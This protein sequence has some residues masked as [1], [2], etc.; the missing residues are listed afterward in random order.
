MGA[1]NFV[2]GISLSP[3]GLPSNTETTNVVLAA[4]A[5]KH[6]VKVPQTDRTI[7]FVFST[8]LLSLFGVLEWILLNTFYFSFA[9]VG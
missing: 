9:N 5:N 3:F 6:V 1:K 2:T 7:E 8:L 4:V